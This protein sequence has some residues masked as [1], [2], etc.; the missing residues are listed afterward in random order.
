[1]PCLS[2]SGRQR[3]ERIDQGVERRIPVGGALADHAPSS[4]A[5]VISSPKGS[6]VCTGAAGGGAGS[7]AAAA[8]AG[9]ADG[10]AAGAGLVAVPGRASAG[11]G[12][13]AAGAGGAAI[14]PAPG[15]GPAKSRRPGSA[16]PGRGGNERMRFI[17]VFSMAASSGGALARNVPVHAGKASAILTREPGFRPMTDMSWGCAAGAVST[18]FTALAN[19]PSFAI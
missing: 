11:G 9:G 1:M 12:A 6:A 10:L 13:G 4:A 3:L 18:R 15:R 7:A 19:P 17:P 14:A 5:S 16:R 8:V 2:S